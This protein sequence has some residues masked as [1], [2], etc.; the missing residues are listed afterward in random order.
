[1][2]IL[3]VLDSSKAITRLGRLILQMNLSMRDSKALIFGILFGLQK[4]I[5]A[6]IEMKLDPEIVRQVNKLSEPEQTFVGLSELSGVLTQ[7]KDTDE[8]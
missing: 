7:R 8:R 4:E 2:I 5:S 3:G 6:I 1:M